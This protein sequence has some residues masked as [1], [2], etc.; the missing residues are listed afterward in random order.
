MYLDSIKDIKVP[1]VEEERDLISKAQSG[2]I[3][4]RNKLVTANLKFVVKCVKRFTNSRVPILD[5]IEEGNMGLIEA[6]NHFDLNCKHRFTTYA[7]WWINQ[8]IIKYFQDKSRL[9]RIPVNKSNE[10]V[11]INK[12]IDNYNEKNE[13]VDYDKIAQELGLDINAVI[14]LVNVACPTISFDMIL[15]DDDENSNAS[16]YDVIPSDLPAIEDILENEDER[17][18]LEKII[19]T[20]PERE[21]NVIKMRYGFNNFGEMSLEDIGQ[22]FNLTKERVRQLESNALETIKKK[23]EKTA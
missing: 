15:D 17:K 20:L 14:N 8:S 21:K 7:I 10:L 23:L 9:I 1:S 18:N 4:A 16:I 5:L 22:T 13:I 2:D 12:M 6:V 3:S 19:D 11:R